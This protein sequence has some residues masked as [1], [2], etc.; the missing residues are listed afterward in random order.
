MSREEDCE[1][2]K[3]KPG[4]RKPRASVRVNY[5]RQRVVDSKTIETIQGQI[6]SVFNKQLLVPTAS[7]LSISDPVN[8]F[9]KENV[10]G[11]SLLV[12]SE[13]T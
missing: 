2:V 5:V 1:A 13:S 11:S 9:C 10:G 6:G 3:L 4:P 7:S 12:G 8:D